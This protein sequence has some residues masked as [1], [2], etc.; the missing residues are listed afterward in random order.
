MVNPPRPPQPPR[1]RATARQRQKALEL[2]REFEQPSDSKAP[3]PAAIAEEEIDTGDLDRPPASTFFYLI[4]VFGTIP[5][6]WTLYR[7]GGTAEQRRISRLAVTLAL[8]W[9]GGYILLETGANHAE[10]LHLPLLLTSSLLSSGYFVV[11]IWLMV[12]LWRRR[13]IDLPGI[14]RI[15]DG[16]IGKPPV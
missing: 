2:L 13:R 3:E 9:L 4:P 7:R 6:L 12:R 15:A 16:A 14:G 10:S 5:A 8:L 11:N 1:D